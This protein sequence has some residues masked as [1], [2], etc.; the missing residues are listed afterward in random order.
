MRCYWTQYLSRGQMTRL[1]HASKPLTRFVLFCYTKPINVKPIVPLMNSAQRP[2]CL[3]HAIFRTAN[4]QMTIWLGPSTR[5][6]RNC[7]SSLLEASTVGSYHGSL[8]RSPSDY[9]RLV[10]HVVYNILPPGPFWGDHS[11]NNE[12]SF[13]VVLWRKKGQNPSMS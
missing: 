6:F 3:R 10:E 9:Q 12:I 4:R 7:C 8:Y 5:S 11:W 13:R 2:R 1:R